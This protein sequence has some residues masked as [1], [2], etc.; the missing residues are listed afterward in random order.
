[1]VQVLEYLAR[2]QTQALALAPAQPITPAPELT[3]PAPMVTPDVTEPNVSMSEED[4]DAISIAA[5]WEGGSFLQKQLLQ[6]APLPPLTI[7][8][9]QSLTITRNRSL[10][11]A[12][13]CTVNHDPLVN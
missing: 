1:M 10:R 6:S 12:P 3:P 2:Q 7:P 9:D 4:H 13:F 5:S 11:Y 8:L